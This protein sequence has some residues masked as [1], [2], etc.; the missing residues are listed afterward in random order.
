MTIE[1]LR[2]LLPRWAVWI[3]VSGAWKA[4][5]HYHGSEIEIANGTPESLLASCRHLDRVDP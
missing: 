3:S 1:D 4:C 2:A 5:R